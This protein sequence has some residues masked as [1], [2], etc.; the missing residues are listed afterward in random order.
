MVTIAQNGSLLKMIMG[1]AEISL[2]TELTQCFPDVD[3]AMW[4]N[5]YICTAKKLKIAQGFENG[6]FKPNE[7]VTDLEAL[8]F[9]LRA[10]GL[11]PTVKI[12]EEWYTAYQDFADKNNILATHTYTT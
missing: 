10:F 3:R 4:Y 5:K 1:A 12:G 9:G 6:T 8:A 7:T 11:T 2:T